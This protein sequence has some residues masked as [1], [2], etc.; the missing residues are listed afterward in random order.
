MK[1]SQKFQKAAKRAKDAGKLKYAI[2]F[3]KAAFR[4]FQKAEKVQKIIKGAS[5]GFKNCLKFV[6]ITKGGKFLSFLSYRY[7]LL[8]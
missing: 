7:F 6:G 5:K 3:G 2:N 1:N 8:F 4:Q